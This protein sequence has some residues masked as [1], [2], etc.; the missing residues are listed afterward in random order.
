MLAIDPET[1]QYY[2]MLQYFAERETVLCLPSSPITSFPTANARLV[3]HGMADPCITLTSG[4]GLVLV[5]GWQAHLPT[6][7]V[8]AGRAIGA[9]DFK[10]YPYSSARGDDVFFVAARCSAQNPLLKARPST[11]E[12]RKTSEATLRNGKQA[13]SWQALTGNGWFSGVKRRS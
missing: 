3:W 11:I 6:P 8:G 9:L 1:K 4:K 7:L 10:L 5:K 12:E 2:D 13:K